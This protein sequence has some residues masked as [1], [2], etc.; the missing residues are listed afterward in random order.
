MPDNLI[1]KD[2]TVRTIVLIH[3]HN[4][5]AKEV[6][7]LTVKKGQ[8]KVKFNV[9]ASEFSTFTMAY[10]DQALP[11]EEAPTVRKVTRTRVTVNAVVGQEYSIDGGNTWV[12]PGDGEDTVKFTGLKAG[13]DYE[14]ITRV[15]THGD[16]AASEPSKPTKVTTEEEEKDESTAS[17]GAPRTSDDA[18]IALWA[19]LLVASIAGI[20]AILAKKRKKEQK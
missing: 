15:A 14:I 20:V 13:T 1:P 16:I 4:G 19:L 7:R 8:K 5:K 3:V 18:Q 11:P 12:K 9:K 2:N 6:G 17:S 10:Q